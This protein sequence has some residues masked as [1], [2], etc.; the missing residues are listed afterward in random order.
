M[1]TEQKGLDSTEG[2]LPGQPGALSLN[3]AR[4]AETG[5]DEE[6]AR[7]KTP[8][9][10][11]PMVL[12]M[13][14]TVGQRFACSPSACVVPRDIARPRSEAASAV[15]HCLPSSHFVLCLSASDH[16]HTATQLPGCKP[17]WSSTSPRFSTCV[18][19]TQCGWPAP[20][21]TCT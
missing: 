21:S 11:A 7:T 15:Y 14:V 2:E 17:F 4:G 8:Y 19:S 10:W 1:A 9:P 16:H 3:T 20:A 18:R 5:K 13:T 12:L 6:G